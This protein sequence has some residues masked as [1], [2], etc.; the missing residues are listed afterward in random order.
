MELSIP[1]DIEIIRTLL[2]YREHQN[3]I[4]HLPIKH[5]DLS[6]AG[7]KLSALFNLFD[8]DWSVISSFLEEKFWLSLF[9]YDSELKDSTILTSKGIFSIKDL[10]DEIEGLFAKYRDQVALKLKEHDKDNIS[11]ELIDRIIK[12]DIGEAFEYH[13]NADLAYLVKRG[14]LFMGMKVKCVHCGSNKWYSLTELRD[15]LSCKG[16]NNEIIPNIDSKVYYK[17][18][19]IV[20]NNIQSDQTR[21]TKQ[22]DGNYIVLKTLLYLRKSGFFSGNSFSWSPPLDIWTKADSKPWTDL[23]IVVVQDGE[24]ILGEAKSNA[25]EFTAKV[26]NNLIWVADNIKPD[27]IIVACNTGNLDEAVEKINARKNNP[28]CEIISYKTGKPWYHFHGLFGLP[29]DNSR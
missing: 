27:K 8:Q 16:C 14:G 26:I 25:S 15:K 13:I 11:D 4:V 23:D 19:E 18:S 7:Q 5:V 21:N 12:R 10:Y 22:F 1:A 29:G 6:N 24:F 9:I 20:V 28:N 2:I 17:L 3:T